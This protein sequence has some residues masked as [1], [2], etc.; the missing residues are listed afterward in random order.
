MQN[1]QSTPDGTRVALRD[2]AVPQE[3]GRVVDAEAEELRKEFEDPL[4]GWV[5][6]GDLRA[7]LGG[8]R[9]AWRHAYIVGFQ[10]RRTRR[11]ALPQSYVF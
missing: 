7:A 6:A 2:A 11:H 9:R 8:C 4:L 1:G 10:R 3:L 5:A